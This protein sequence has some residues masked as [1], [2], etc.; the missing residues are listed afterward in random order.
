M[1]GDIKCPKYSKLL[2]ETWGTFNTPEVIELYQPLSDYSG[3]ILSKLED[4]LLLYDNLH[5]QVSGRL[6]IHKF[7]VTIRHCF[8]K[9]GS[10]N[11]TSIL[12]NKMYIAFEFMDG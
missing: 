7:I 8:L 11:L 6:C 1:K 10:Q 12:V 3:R 2:K 4:L 9:P 5:F